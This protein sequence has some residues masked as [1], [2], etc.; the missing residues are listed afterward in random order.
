MH[1]RRNSTSCRDFAWLYFVKHDIE[2]VDTTLHK[3]VVRAVPI[4]SCTILKKGRFSLN[5]SFIFSMTLITYAGTVVSFFLY[6]LD[7]WPISI[8]G[9]NRD[10]QAPSK[11]YRHLETVAGEAT[12]KSF[13]SNIMVKVAE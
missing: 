6:S 1:L 10:V 9:F 4:T 5:M 12:A 2:D 7:E 8:I 13:T 3:V 11:P